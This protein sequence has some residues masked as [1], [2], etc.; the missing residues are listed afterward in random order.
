MTSLGAGLPPGVEP[1][2][3]LPEHNSDSDY[4]PPV[5]D[6][7]KDPAEI[8]S[9]VDAV[10]PILPERTVKAYIVKYTAYRTFVD[11]P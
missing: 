7:I 3:D 4:D 6:T 1:V 9:P 8:Q 2:F 5:E 11:D 10:A